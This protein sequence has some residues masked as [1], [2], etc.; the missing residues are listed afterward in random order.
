MCKIHRIHYSINTLK[1]SV[2]EITECIVI[3]KKIGKCDCMRFFFVGYTLY[4][5]AGVASVPTEALN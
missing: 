3:L 4:V 2:N 1:N 5:C